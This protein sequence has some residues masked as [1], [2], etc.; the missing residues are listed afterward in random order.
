MKCTRVNCPCKRICDKNNKD[1]IQQCEFYT[2]VKLER[3]HIISLKDIECL[4]VL[5]ALRELK[6]NEETHKEDKRI[7]EQ[8][9][10]K[11]CNVVSKDKQTK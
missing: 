6:N 3:K 10:E 4:V 11:I 2:D 9:Y 7:A 8:I 1:N 5:D